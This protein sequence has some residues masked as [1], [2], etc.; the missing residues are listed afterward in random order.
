MIPCPLFSTIA[1]SK[2]QP[3]SLGF[4]R[5]SRKK[6]PWKEWNWKVCPNGR[7]LWG[8]RLQLWAGKTCSWQRRAAPDDFPGAE[9]TT[10]DSQFVKKRRGKG[11]G[12]GSFFLSGGGGREGPFFRGEG[13]RV[14]FVYPS[15][16][17]L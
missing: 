3:F 5:L 2:N 6:D 15:R 13:G 11:A 14:D 4:R 7:Q 10:A 17:T 9:A 12:G 16:R 1:L 8:L